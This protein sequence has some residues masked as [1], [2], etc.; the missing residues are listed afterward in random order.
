MTIR[1]SGDFE[2]ANQRLATEL[3]TLAMQLDVLCQRAYPSAAQMEAIAAALEESANMARE[4]ADYCNPPERPVISSK[5]S[6]VGFDLDGTLAEYHRFS[7]A[8][9]IGAPVLVMTAKCRALIESGTKVRII[10]ARGSR[11]AMDRALAY[12]AIERWCEKHL[13][14]VLPITTSKDLHMLALYDDRAIQ[15]GRNTGEILGDE[16]QALERPDYLKE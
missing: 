3:M 7:T 13:G 1:G 14:H 10:T 4:L 8:D 9:Q 15:V 6:W 16:Q 11:D 2:C 12:P 5:D